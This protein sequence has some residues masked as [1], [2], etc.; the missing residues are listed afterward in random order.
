MSFAVLWC[1]RSK[2][3]WPWHSVWW[4]VVLVGNP[5]ISPNMFCKRKACHTHMRKIQPG[6][7]KII[8]WKRIMYQTSNFKFTF[9]SA[10]GM[11]RL[12]RLTFAMPWQAAL[13]KKQS[14]EALYRLCVTELIVE[15]LPLPMRVW[16]WCWLPWIY[17]QGEVLSVATQTNCYDRSMEVWLKIEV[18]EM[19]KWDSMTWS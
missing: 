19:R 2:F 17:H 16:T 10:H 14:D 6:I 8:T 13:R 12:V 3:I 7:S 18:S 5:S 9:P 15:Q 1:S 4:S 11:P